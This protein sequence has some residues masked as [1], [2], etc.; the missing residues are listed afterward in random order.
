MDRHRPWPLPRFAS[1]FP[2]IIV[3]QRPLP[4]EVAAQWLNHYLAHL[5]HLPP[6]EAVVAASQD[7]WG[8]DAGLTALSTFWVRRHGGFDERQEYAASVYDQ[9]QAKAI[10]A[11][12]AQQFPQSLMPSRTYLGPDGLC[13]QARELRTLLTLAVE[14]AFEI[15]EYGKGLFFSKNF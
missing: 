15:G 14:T 5:Q 8:A 4:A 9:E 3:S 12:E 7:L 13:R 6:D 10:R 1:W 11:F 2:H